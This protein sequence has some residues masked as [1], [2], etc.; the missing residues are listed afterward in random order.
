MGKKQFLK[1]LN[2]KD[3]ILLITYTEDL[4]RTNVMVHFKKVTGHYLTYLDKEINN[5]DIIIVL[6]DLTN[7]ETFI[8]LNGWIPIIQETTKNRKPIL[9]LGTKSDLTDLREVE[10]PEVLKIIEKFQV[11][12]E[13]IDLTMF[14]NIDH[15]IY[16]SLFTLLEFY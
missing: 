6:I 16:N 14:S 11:S 4:K 10:T 5:A 9:I 15:I 7:K 1:T 2:K 12:Y 3:N 13:E 8:N